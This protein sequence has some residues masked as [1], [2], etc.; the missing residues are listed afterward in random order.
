MT[1]RA[2]TNLNIYTIVCNGSF[3][4]NVSAKNT[5]SAI[6][7]F[8][9]SNGI[10]M[11][12]GKSFGECGTPSDFCSKSIFNGMRACG[13]RSKCLPTYLYETGIGMMTATPV[14]MGSGRR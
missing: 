13:R 4:G 5:R 8:C 12:N 3:M 10:M 2:G 1:Y 9:N 7:A 14:C 6:I 11:G